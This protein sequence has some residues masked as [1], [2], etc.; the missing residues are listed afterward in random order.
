M[1]TFEEGT[2]ELYDL[3]SKWFGEEMHSETALAILIVCSEKLRM[4]MQKQLN[5]VV[6]E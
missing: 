5:E 4:I 1:K 6:D 2:E 3:V